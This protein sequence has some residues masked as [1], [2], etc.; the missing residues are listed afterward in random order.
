MHPHKINALII[1]LNEGNIH[2]NFE[3]LP[4]IKQLK[5]IKSAIKFNYGTQQ[6]KKLYKS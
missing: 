1:S 5:T 3:R 4:V 6:K 2:V